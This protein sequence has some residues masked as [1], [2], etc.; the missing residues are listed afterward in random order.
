MAYEPKDGDISLFKN[1][2]KKET[3]HP[4][5]KGTALIEGKKYKIAMWMRESAKKEKFISG[6][7]E[8][9][10]YRNPENDILDD[11]TEQDSLF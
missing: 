6:K 9:D 7:I 4:D 3:K 1:S 5:Y 10:N 2:D 8:I 11:I